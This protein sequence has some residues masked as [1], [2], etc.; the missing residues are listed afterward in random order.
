MSKLDKLNELLNL[1]IAL[2]VGLFTGHSVYILQDYNK[3]PDLYAMRS[4]P[5][6]MSIVVYA[7]LTVVVIAIAVIIKVVA[8]KK[9]KNS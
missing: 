5:W 7:V 4:A 2:V 8:H 9:M 3:Y 6:Y 1:I